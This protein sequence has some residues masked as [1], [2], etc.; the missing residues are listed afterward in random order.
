MEEDDGFTDLFC[1][2]LKGTSFISFFIWKK[3]QSTD[4][5]VFQFIDEH[6]NQN[7]L[8]PVLIIEKLVKVKVLTKGHYMSMCELHLHSNR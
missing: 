6:K 1:Y 4:V 2:L 5:F 8:N 3:G 7:L